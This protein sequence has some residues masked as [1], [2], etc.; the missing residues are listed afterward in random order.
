MNILKEYGWQGLLLGAVLF[1]LYSFL[2]EGLKTLSEKA[3]NKLLQKKE[4]QLKM[5][6]FF[7]AM[8]YSLN[9]EIPAMTLFNDKP[10]RQTLLKDLVYCSLASVEEVAERIAETDHSKWNH[11]EWNYEMRSALNEMNT[12][13]VQKCVNRGMPEIVY[14]KYLVWYFE[15]LNYMRIFI[16][17]IA[18]TESY[19]TPESKTA[20]L[21]LMF[22]LFLVTFIGDAE[23]TLKEL[24]GEI[25]G[26]YYK[27]G[28][29]EPLLPHSAT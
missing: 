5:H 26:L 22:N 28:I 14:K 6:A 4:A 17:Q 18:G 2:G 23:R 9:V 12:E 16:D 20:A 13:F 3:K 15:R 21:F 25:S 1:L 24:N 27:G 7:N 19:A 11:T 10:I 29:V 8:S